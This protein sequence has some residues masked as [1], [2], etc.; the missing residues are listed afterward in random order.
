MRSTLVALILFVTL[1]A[2]TPVTA[3][4]MDRLYEEIV[5]AA[6]A[7]DGAITNY[8]ESRARERAALQSY[9]RNASR[10][11]FEIELRQLSPEEIRA[12]S[13]ALE[14]E[15]EALSA[16]AREVARNRN[17]VLQ[18]GERVLS[19]YEQK[20]QLKARKQQVPS[21]GL[22]GLWRVH[23][24]DRNE[25]GTLDVR[26]DGAVIDGDY[27]LE[28]GSRGKL[29]GVFQKGTLKLQSID[30]AS[31]A[32]YSLEGKVD[33]DRGEIEG[34]YL[35]IQLDAPGGASGRWEARKLSWEETP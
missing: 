24:P 28:S 19:L 13:S 3:Q 23:I 8:E 26:L 27:A 12:M 10:F 14:A 7:L 17:Q 34:T 9:L 5:R 32:R 18:E 20:D 6:R 30:S 11:D 33:L 1:S 16:R 31:G 35:A 15:A 4:E 29:R 25:Y 22:V 21:A 2:P